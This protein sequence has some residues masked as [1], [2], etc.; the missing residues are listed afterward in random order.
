MCG[1][2]SSY[3]DRK[4]FPAIVSAVERAS[5]NL[6]GKI[7]QQGRHSGAERNIAQ[8][9]IVISTL[10]RNA[11]LLGGCRRQ[12]FDDTVAIFICDINAFVGDGNGSHADSTDCGRGFG[13]D[14]KP[15]S[16]FAMMFSFMAV[17]NQA[18]IFADP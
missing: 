18:A 14:G 6:K 17:F 12:Q 3:E 5:A 10:N 8:N 9:G 7:G 1:L 13:Q 15:P 4:K 2:P 11:D 16:Y